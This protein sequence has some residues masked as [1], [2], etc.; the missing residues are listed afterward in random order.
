MSHKRWVSHASA[1]IEGIPVNKD[2]VPI[3]YTDCVF[4]CWY[5][6]EGQDLSS[7]EEFREI[8]EPHTQL[9]NIYMGIFKILFGKKKLSFFSKLIGKSN[10]VTDEERKLARAK[11][12][13]LEEVSKQ[14]IGK[15]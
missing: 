9:H 3:N 13:I 6:D 15:L 4:G 8:E 14:I 10:S 1:M 12:R 7:L 2:Q 11:F 5:Y